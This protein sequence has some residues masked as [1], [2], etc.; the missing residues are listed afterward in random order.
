MASLLELLVLPCRW[1]CSGGGA[2]PLVGSCV[3][4]RAAARGESGRGPNL[5][6]V[7][8]SCAVRIRRTSSPECT[9]DGRSSAASLQSRCASNSTNQRSSSGSVPSG[10]SSHCESR[11]NTCAYERGSMPGSNVLSSTSGLPALSSHACNASPRSSVASRMAPRC[12]ERSAR[13][14]ARSGCRWRWLSARSGRMP[15][16]K[17]PSARKAAARACRQ[18][19]TCSCSMSG[20]QSGSSFSSAASGS[21]A[22]SLG[23]KPA[24]MEASNFPYS[25]AIHA[26]R[27]ESASRSL[28]TGAEVTRAR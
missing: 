9:A 16:A 4:A 12:C 3:S 6:A 25:R 5:R 13:S 24:R 28:I 18:P 10:T 17:R 26:A 19:I 2:V 22:P 20:S 27:Y 14:L 7:R 11:A 15:C 8:Y 23:G 21:D 1:P